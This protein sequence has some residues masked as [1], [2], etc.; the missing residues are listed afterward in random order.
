M[1]PLVIQIIG[2]VIGTYIGGKIY[3]CVYN[4]PQLHPSPQ[5]TKNNKNNLKDI[6]DNQVQEYIH[7]ANEYTYEYDNEHGNTIQFFKPM[8]NIKLKNEAKNGN[9]DLYEDYF[10]FKN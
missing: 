7:N 6:P 10:I 1:A 9:E 3:N 2:G 8:K 4:K 5:S